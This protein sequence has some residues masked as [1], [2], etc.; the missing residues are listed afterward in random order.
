MSTLTNAHDFTMNSPAFVDQSFHHNKINVMEKVREKTGLHMLLEASMPSASHDSSARYPPPLCHPGTRKEFLKT[1]ER[2]GLNADNHPDRIAWLKGPAGVGK[3]AIAQSCAE[4]FGSRLG[5]SFF[6]SRPNKWD[7]PNRFFTSI[8]YQLAVKFNPYGDL[9]N[10]KFLHNPA[11]VE[12]S[13]P[14]QFQDLIADP[15]CELRLRGEEFAE[16]VIIVDGFDECASMEA[17]VDI[18]RIIADSVRHQST[19]FLWIF[20]SRLEPDLIATFHSP[21]ISPFCFIIEIT[22]SRANDGEV[23]LYLT[24]KLREIGRREELP[25]PWPSEEE[26]W[27]VV[28]LANGLFIYAATVVLFV[29][30][31][32][33]TGPVNQLRA[34]LNLVHRTAKEGTKHPL[35]RLNIFYSLI[36]ECIPPQRRLIVLSILL[37]SRFRHIGVD[38]TA[39]AS[40]LGLSQHQ[41]RNACRSLHAVMF[42]ARELEQDFVIRFYNASFMDFLEDP[43]RSQ[44]C[45]IWSDSVVG[46]VW[47][48]IIRKL[49]QIH[50]ACREPL[51]KCRSYTPDFELTWPNGAFLSTVYNGMVCGFFILLKSIHL[52]GDPD[53]LSALMKF[54]FRRLCFLA[55]TRVVGMQVNSLLQI[56]PKHS[57]LLHRDIIRIPFRSSRRITI[58]HGKKKAVVEDSKSE[59]PGMYVRPHSE[60]DIGLFLTRLHNQGLAESR[61]PRI[62]YG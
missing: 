57:K 56:I 58:G 22:I 21:E 10:G 52:D 50:R 11:L 37:T 33:S 8:S 51:G 49:N 32:D 48:T 43:K 18:I 60:R 26:I 45:S 46:F 5:A 25:Q 34:V 35:S 19:P 6:F 62:R 36:L 55:P 40:L 41:F 9:L 12:K 16:H 44:D 13:M 39:N 24:D 53:R 7:D 59:S 27:T 2:W 14:H 4:A 38:A 17:Q 42:I 3:S 15:I 28:D 29:N 47:D 31:K 61:N 20:F 54:D 30:D 23:S 1:L